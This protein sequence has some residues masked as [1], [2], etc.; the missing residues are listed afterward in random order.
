MVPNIQKNMLFRT[1]SDRCLTACKIVK[2]T[3]LHELYSKNFAKVRYH[4]LK[5][6]YELECAVHVPKNIMF[7]TL[8]YKLTKK[9]EKKMNSGKQ[10]ILFNKIILK[11]V[12]NIND[13]L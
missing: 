4:Y 10:N 5:K 1:Y 6:I 8:Q 7:T 2:H 3:D 9:I 11:T 12:E 13:L